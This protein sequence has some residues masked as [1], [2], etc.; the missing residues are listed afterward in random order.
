MDVGERKGETFGKNL[1]LALASEKIVTASLVALAS[2]HVMGQLTAQFTTLNC[3]TL[4][5]TSNIRSIT[6]Y[7]RPT[8]ALRI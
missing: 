8:S 4:S 6:V 3:T 1:R 2:R 5:Q 7:L